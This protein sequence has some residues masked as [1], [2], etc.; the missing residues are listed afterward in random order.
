ME[1][2]KRIYD[3]EKKMAE[4]PNG[5][6]YVLNL[7]RCN[8]RCLF[9][10]KKE[11]ILN[12]KKI[13]RESVLREIVK[14]KKEGYTK[15]DFFG[16]EP[17]VFIFLSEAI[18]FAAEIGLRT[19]LATNGTNFASASYAKEFFEK[20]R[21]SA[22]K[23][24]ISVHSHLSEIHDR[25][26]CVKGSHAKTM[27]GISRIIKHTKPTINVVITTLNQD[28][29][30]EIVERMYS[31]G[32]RYIKFSC[33]VM[34]GDIVQNKWLFA[35]PTEYMSQLAKALV[36]AKKLNFEFIGL[37]KFPRRLFSVMI[38]TGIDWVVPVELV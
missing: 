5:S 21:K 38:D 8:Q 22:T 34:H 4:D 17:I 36:L 25:I 32:V 7:D 11:D 26:T 35:K 37:E 33:L 23:I 31:M 29:L 30:E 1:K 10:M 20:N 6:E 13:T 9:C 16:G 18:A 14:A 28:H 2:V 27:E 15:I 12:C 3:F 19:A 24:R